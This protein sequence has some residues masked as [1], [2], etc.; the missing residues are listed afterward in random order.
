MVFVVMGQLGTSVR[1]AYQVL[2]SMTIITNF[3]P[4]LFMFAALIRLQ[5]EPAPPN[6]V[7]VPGGKPVATLIAIV[8]FVATTAVIVGSVIP[9]AAETNKALAVSKV[10][11]M[12]VI[13]LGGGAALYG[14]GKRRLQR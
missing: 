9:D 3:V 14:A 6:I 10:V 4:Y 13:L 12:S 5:A 11:L 7:R 8:G 2:V 1:G